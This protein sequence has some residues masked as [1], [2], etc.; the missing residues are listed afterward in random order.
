MAGRWQQPLRSH[1]WGKTNKVRGAK[2]GIPGG[3][4]DHIG[5]LPIQGV[6]A[7][8]PRAMAL[9]TLASGKQAL[10]DAL[11]TIRFA[12]ILFADIVGSTRLV[13][14]LDPEDAR[15]IL[16]RT[17][18]V[19]IDAIHECGGLVA[20]VQGDGVMA[21][22]GV[23]PAAHDHALRAA[24]ASR[25]AIDR[26]RSGVIGM[27]P[28][29]QLRIG[30]HAG[31][32][33]LRRQDND[34]GSV[35][36]VVGHAAHVAGRAEKAAPA[37]SVAITQSTLSLIAEQCAVRPLGALPAEQDEGGM[38]LLELLEVELAR[39]DHV[40]VKGSATFPVVGRDA[41]MARVRAL[42]EI[43]SGGRGGSLRIAGEAGMG[44]SRLLLE[45]SRS[46][47]GRG[48]VFVSV[49]GNA[50]MATVPFGCLAGP[51]RHLAG[52]LAQFGLSDEPEPAHAAD[53]AASAEQRSFLE[54]F[55]AGRSDW[56]P[57]SAPGERNRIASQSLLGLFRKVA[58][59]AP[60]LVLGD[61]VQYMDMAT[62]GVLNAL[63]DHAGEPGEG[64]AARC[65]VLLAGRP[66]GA[67]WQGD[68]AARAIHLGPLC[69]ADSRQMIALV[70]AEQALPQEIVD[71][72]LD[73]AGGLPL[74]L[75][76]FA[77]S[78][79]DPEGRLPARLD[80]LL[81]ERLA[82]LDDNAT[83]LCQICAAL[84]PAFPDGRLRE[85]AR[86]WCARPDEA[87]RTLTAQRVLEHGADGQAR[88]THQLVQEAAYL[89][90]SRRRRKTIHARILAMLE[91]G[92]TLR[93]IG[94][95][96]H[97]ELAAHAEKAGL[98]SHAIDHLWNACQ[99]ALGLAAIESVVQLYRRACTMT[100]QLDHTEAPRV[101]ARFAM[102]AFD[103]LQQLSCEQET[104]NDMQAI[105]Q[106]QVD[107]GPA[108]RTVARIN[109]ALLD[110]IDGAPDAA[111]Q[112]LAQ[113][114]TDLASHESL[115]RRTYADVVGAYIANSLARPHEAIARIERLGARLDEGQRSKTFG[116]VVVIPHILARSFGAWYQ[117]DLGQDAAARDW[118][119]EALWLSR[120]HAHA[121][122]RLL[123]DLA[124]GYHHYRTGRSAHALPIL[125]RAYAD[126]LQR[127]FLGFEPASASWLALCLIEQELCD[128]AAAVLEEAVARGHFRKIRTSATYY[129]HEARARLALAQGDTA[130]A[131]LRAQEALEHCRACGEAMHELHALVLIEEVLA[132]QGKA[133]QRTAERAALAARIAAA[134]VV[135]L[136]KRLERLAAGC[137]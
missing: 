54:A 89:T 2:S 75:Q 69:T 12:T 137:A 41:E 36:D 3:Q 67:W 108:A 58:G 49:R 55:L 24:L 104:R 57:E 116:A 100:A 95:V 26:L 76:E 64:E 1:T 113:A 130:S 119:A 4:P 53:P 78:A 40:P 68:G 29:P 44:K 126:C 59:H 23:H 124:L 27:L 84:G 88:F 96:D 5:H 70:S 136:S 87:I 120:R 106:G 90:M 73:R 112:W 10:A 46:A 105:A 94:P 79:Q 28:A 131:A 71:S 117:T 34:F 123:A 30:L 121:Y 15:D 115:P 110:W 127:R 114:E 129:L 99:Q 8:G 101:R 133:A 65:G 93:D 62:L 50:L 74:A 132:T 135:I 17:V 16:D 21:V 37:G 39:A 103:A 56:L 128:E 25:R 72:I 48:V 92:P 118:L 52:L 97:A 43:L 81:A 31:P 134:G 33:L 11:D 80:N 42:V 66:E 111:A 122:S 107:F 32:V 61:D 83:R 86:R 9:P 51:A 7:D 14:T 63:A 77:V 38:A 18:Q 98:P 109:M 20:R 60:L 91:E 6:H 13:S 47:A 35:V 22:F 45:A 85:A 102:L 82:G 19:V 125:R